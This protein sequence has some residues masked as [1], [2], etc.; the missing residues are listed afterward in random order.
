M[1]RERLTRLFGDESTQVVPHNHH[2]ADTGI[3]RAGR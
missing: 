1:L 3:E 2:A